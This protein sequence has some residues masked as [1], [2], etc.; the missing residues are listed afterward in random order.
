MGGGDNTKIWIR[1]TQL[2]LRQVDR[3]NILKD[4][5]GLGAAR[6]PILVLF[7]IVRVMAT[8]CEWVHVVHCPNNFSS[9]IQKIP[10]RPVIQH[11]RHPMEVDY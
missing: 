9:G 6:T 7:A 5:S 8:T 2:L 10:D 4:W 11:P 3:H 1:F